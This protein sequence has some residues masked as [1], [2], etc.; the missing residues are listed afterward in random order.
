MRLQLHRYLNHYEMIAL[1]IKHNLLSEK[2]FREWMGRSC[3]RDWNTVAHFIHED[4]K[5]PARNKEGVRYDDNLYKHFQWLARRIDS[6]A[7]SLPEHFEKKE[8]EQAD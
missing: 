6:D 2:I 8:K 7:I 5:S 1:G 3:V 4:R